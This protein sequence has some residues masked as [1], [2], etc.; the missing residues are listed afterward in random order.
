MS[1]A[2]RASEGR[3][4]HVMFHGP[5]SGLAPWLSGLARWLSG[6]ARTP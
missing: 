3:V 4:E 2:I 6:F 1:V 5:L